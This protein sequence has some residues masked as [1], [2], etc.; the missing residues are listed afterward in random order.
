MNDKEYLEL[1]YDHALKEM[2]NAQLEN[3]R[4]LQIISTIEKVATKNVV[5][6]SNMLHSPRSIDDYLEGMKTILELCE[7]AIKE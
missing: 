7:Q 5:R 4:L 3:E 2:E 6:V 1:K